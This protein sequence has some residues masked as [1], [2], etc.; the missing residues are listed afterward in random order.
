MDN[1]Y[2]IFYNHAGDNAP[3][4]AEVLRWKK[5]KVIKAYKSKEGIKMRFGESL[6]NCGINCKCTQC[7][8]EFS[9]IHNN[10]IED[11]NEK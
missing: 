1:I 8:K 4:I 5:T 11:F 3:N 2:S 10:L 9:V 7:K 6:C